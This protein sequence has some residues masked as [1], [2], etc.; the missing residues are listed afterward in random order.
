MKERGQAEVVPRLASWVKELDPNDPEYEHHRLEALWTYQAL[1]VAEPALLKTLLDSN[2]ARVR[3]AA[4][5]VVPFWKTRLAD[6]RSLLADRVERRATARPARGGPGAWP[7]PQPALGRARALRRSIGRSTL[8]RIRALADGP[9]A[10]PIWLPEVQAGRFDF[11]GRPDAV[12]LRTPGG[13]LARD[14]QAA[15][16]LAQGGQGPARAG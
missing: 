8:S 14:G 1:D 13:R 5:R 2:D 11:G 9:R 15:A 3:A 4:T 10:A 6:P 7:S 12:D 16:G